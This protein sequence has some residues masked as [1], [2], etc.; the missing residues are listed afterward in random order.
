MDGAG[1]VLGWRSLFANDIAAGRVVEP[2]DLALP[3]GSSFY[4]VYP[5][6]NSLRSNIVAFRAWLLQEARES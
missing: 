5:E 4:L 1:V 3:L 2:F 6:A